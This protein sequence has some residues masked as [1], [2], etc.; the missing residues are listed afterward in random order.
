MMKKK[1][2]FKKEI[3]APKISRFNKYIQRAVEE[4]LLK[5]RKPDLYTATIPDSIPVTVLR[6]EA[7]EA[8]AFIIPKV[9]YFSSLISGNERI[10]AE[11]YTVTPRRLKEE[12]KVGINIKKLL[13]IIMST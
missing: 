1:V 7:K 3:A 10:S 5:A 12:V 11:I 2:K 8:V 9:I 4:D 6:P 13:R